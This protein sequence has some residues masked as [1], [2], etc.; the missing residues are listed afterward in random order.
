MG[1]LKCGAGGVVVISGPTDHAHQA[2]KSMMMVQ[3]HGA[4]AQTTSAD[5]L[6]PIVKALESD[7]GDV[8]CK[9]GDSRTALAGA[10]TVRVGTQAPVAAQFAFA[11]VLDLPM[12]Q[13]DVKV[14]CLG[15]GFGWS[16]ETDF[17]AQAAAI[18]REAGGG[19]VWAFWTYEQGPMHDFFRPA[20][21]R[22]R[23][24]A[25]GRTRRAARVPWESR[26]AGPAMMHRIVE[27]KLGARGHARWGCERRCCRTTRAAC[28]CSGGPPN[29]RGGRIAGEWD[30][31][32]ETLARQCAAPQF[33][34]RG[35]ASGGGVGWCRQSGPHAR[36]GQCDRLRHR[37]QAEPDSPADG[38][39]QRLRRL[40][41]RLA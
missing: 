21:P 35:G 20:P 4:A 32:H 38:V 28:A 12:A 39:G 24:C 11:Q 29:K 37:G 3:D 18:A 34:Q 40:P 14:L 31:R 33:R 2:A 36:C 7:E 5:I 9:V 10:A 1:A 6:G 41:L 25:P 30:R 16:G 19:P 23:V 27:R 26:S 8:I 17:I 13:V 15:G 22:R